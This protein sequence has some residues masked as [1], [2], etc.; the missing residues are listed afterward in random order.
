MRDQANHSD[1]I[2]HDDRND[3]PRFVESVWPHK[4]YPFLY[5]SIPQT[6]ESPN[7]P[8]PFTEEAGDND[9]MDIFDIGGEIGYIGQ[10]KAVKIL[11]ALAVNDVSPSRPNRT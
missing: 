11:G 1:P 4:T 5:G 7:F 6:W 3:L 10:V 2:F 8:H 9:P